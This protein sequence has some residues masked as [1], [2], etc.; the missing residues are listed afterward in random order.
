[1]LVSNGNNLYLIQSQPIYQIVCNN[2]DQ[3]TETQNVMYLLI[4]APQVINN[5]QSIS[6][7]SSSSYKRQFTTTQRNIISRNKNNQNNYNI[8]NMCDHSNHRKK[9]EM[10]NRQEPKFSSFQKLSDNNLKFDESLRCKYCN[11]IF[12]RKGNLKQ[13]ILVH[14]KETPFKCIIF[15]YFVLYLNIFMISINSIFVFNYFFR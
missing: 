15:I 10:Q 5:N 8:V 7:S 11:K 2:N 4:N 14:T 1:M 13:H 3:V 9:Q 12:K 6:S